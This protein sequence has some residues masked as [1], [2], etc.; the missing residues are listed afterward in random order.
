V[1]ADKRCGEDLFLSETVLISVPENAR[2]FT[3]QPV[4]ATRPL[5]AIE[6]VRNRA[7]RWAGA[8]RH[9]R[10]DASRGRPPARP[11]AA[12]VPLM[13]IAH[14]AGISANRAGW[15]HGGHGARTVDGEGNVT[16]V[17]IV[18]N[19]ARVLTVRS[20]DALRWKFRPAPNRQ[21]DAE[22]GFA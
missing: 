7:V 20:T 12:G 18:V 17:R 11:V 3:L 10:S 5:T 2:R 21:F 1:N 9:R 14:G 15:R 8:A 6:P 16:A 13:P 22:I 4:T 19:R